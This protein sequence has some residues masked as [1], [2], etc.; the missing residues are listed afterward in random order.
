MSPPML[1]SLKV[2][3]I[4]G[5]KRLMTLVGIDEKLHPEVAPDFGFTLGFRE[6]SLGVDEVR[7]DAIEI[8]F[9][10]S[11]DHAKH[12]IRI[13]LTGDVRNPPVIANDRDLLR[14]LLPTFEIL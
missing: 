13:G 7:L 9:R 14:L 2:S 4:Q 12:G 10:L 8:V 11:V 3:A 5:S 6:P 1:P